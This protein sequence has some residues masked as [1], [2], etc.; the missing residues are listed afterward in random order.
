MK[1]ERNPAYPAATILKLSA[2]EFEVFCD[3][4]CGI[5]P[6]ETAEKYELSP[7]TVATYRQRIIEK[8]GVKS[9]QE[10]ALLAYL[11]GITQVHNEKKQPD[12]A[13][14]EPQSQEGEQALLPPASAEAGS[15]DTGGSSPAAEGNIG[16]AA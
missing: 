14:A 6:Q 5:T 3:I 1:I 7:K 15:G 13:T 8:L 4:A 9:N 2:R 10:I 12:A 16:E 11:E